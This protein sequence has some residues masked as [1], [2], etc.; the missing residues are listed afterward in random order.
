[1]KVLLVMRMA[2]SSVVP[3]TLLGVQEKGA[4]SLPA[5]GCST[6]YIV[7]SRGPREVRSRAPNRRDLDGTPEVPHRPYLDGY[8]RLH[9]YMVL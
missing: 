7:M 4:P 8:P 2:V 3:R 1:V 6:L 5:V 9:L